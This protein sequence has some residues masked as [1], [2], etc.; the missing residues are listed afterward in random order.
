[1]IT[2]IDDRPVAD[3]VELVVAI[4]THVKGDRVRL[5]VLRNGQTKQVEVRLGASPDT[6]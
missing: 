1:M 6:P 3:T 5:T 4:R 2:R